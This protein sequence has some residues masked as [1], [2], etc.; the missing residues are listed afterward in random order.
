MKVVSQLMTEPGLLKIQDGC[1]Y[2]CSYC[3]IPL[4][5]GGSRSDSL[6]IYLIM[7]NQFLKMGSKKLF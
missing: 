6:I 4:A 7:S 5:R 2:K 1:D 3:T